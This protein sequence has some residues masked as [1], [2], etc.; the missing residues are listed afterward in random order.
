MRLT[1]TGLAMLLPLLPLGAQ[2]TAPRLT[3]AEEL[4]LDAGTEDFPTRVLV[5]PRGQIVVPINA[6]MQLRV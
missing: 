5:G 6:D 1:R 2:P 4:R 3:L